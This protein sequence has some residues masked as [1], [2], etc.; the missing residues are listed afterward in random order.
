MFRGI[1]DQRAGISLGARRPREAERVAMVRFLW[2]R[3]GLLPA[4]LQNY[5]PQ[6]GRGFC[7]A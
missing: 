7:R 3:N 5:Q 4:S 6:P 1:S 2:P